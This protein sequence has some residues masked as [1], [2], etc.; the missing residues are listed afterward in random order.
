MPA[1]Y[2]PLSPEQLAQLDRKLTP[3]EQA[4]V[5][6]W[7][8]SQSEKELAAERAKG[9]PISATVAVTPKGAV[10]KSMA[11]PAWYE[12]LE[13]WQYLLLG[14][15]VGAVGYGIYKVTK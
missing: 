9:G 13:W 7:Q 12:G 6:E 5:D 8:I 14:A 10:I 4:A 15:G 11:R 2:G 3:T 1:E